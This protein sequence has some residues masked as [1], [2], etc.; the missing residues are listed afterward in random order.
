M[1][2][3]LELNKWEVGTVAAFAALFLVTFALY[4]QGFPLRRYLFYL[5]EEEAGV[6][7]GTVVIKRGNVTREMLG[8]PGFR[9]IETSHPVFNEDTV[10]SGPESTATLQLDDG[11]T[12]ELGENTMVRLSFDTGFS[13]EGI[14]RSGRAAKVKVV[15]GQVKGVAKERKIVLQARNQEEVKVATS[16]EAA[17]VVVQAPPIQVP[18]PIPAAPIPV[19]SAEPLAQASP[20]AVPSELPSPIVSPSPAMLQAAPVN[21]KLQVAS[22]AD[23]G[24][25]PVPTGSTRAVREVAAQ[26]KVVPAKDAPPAFTLVLRRKDPA[27]P[28]AEGEPEFKEV[29]RTAV[30]VKAGKARY[31][32]AI[33]A[34]GIYEY[35]ILGEQDASHAKSRFSIPAEFKAVETLD[36]LIGG[37]AQTSNLLRGER[38]KKFD[39]T[40]RWKEYPGA[41][42][43]RISFL[44]KPGAKPAFEKTV[45]AT[46]YSLNKGKVFTGRIHYKVVANLPTGFR[47][48]SELQPFSFEF[49]PP[50]PVIPTHQATITPKKPGDTSV[51]LTWQKTNFT[52]SYEVEAS[53]DVEFTNPFF[54]KKLV[55]N[56]YILKVPQPGKVYWRVKGYANGVVSPQSDIAEFTMQPSPAAPAKTG[57]AAPTG[58]DPS[59]E[60]PAA[61]PADPDAA[62]P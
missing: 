2:R 46:E 18:I 39:L 13:L 26:W 54:R 40:F 31:V 15:S 45:N 4:T 61:N 44:P 29:A 59:A 33:K 6:Q 38:L 10:V 49:M 42:S 62:S 24:V 48:S 27:Q 51:L 57:A 32:W 58:A 52:E 16:A 9:S 12:I 20:V 14:R 21:W 37:S 41:E 11:G 7:I 19:P 30:P 17:P 28:V 25:Y 23:D 50:I 35:E 36:P 34:P 56:F 55:E 43:Y 47:A 60:T 1:V 3:D 5:P 53:T 8:E 22:P